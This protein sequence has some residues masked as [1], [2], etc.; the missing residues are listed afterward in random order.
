LPGS[1]RLDL[2]A[3]DLE[4]RRT[5]F[6]RFACLDEDLSSMPACGATSSFS[7]FMARH[8]QRRTVGDSIAF[9]DEQPRPCPAWER[10][11]PRRRAPAAHGRSRALTFALDADEP[12]VRW[13]HRIRGRRRE[14]RQTRPFESDRQP[15][16]LALHLGGH[17]SAGAGSASGSLAAER[18]SAARQVG[19]LDRRLSPS[20]VK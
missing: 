17:P 7:I 20:I 14:R 19:D 13:Q 16:P 2:R 15:S 5:A 12:G 9:G 11:E 18:R 8:D 1:F 10:S 6:H 4:Q 3:A